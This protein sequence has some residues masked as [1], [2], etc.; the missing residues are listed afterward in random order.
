MCRVEQSKRHIG[1][2]A[3]R[4]WQASPVHTLPITVSQ[5]FFT[6]S[7]CTKSMAFRSSDPRGAWPKNCTLPLVTTA[8]TSLFKWPVGTCKPQ[9][10]L[11]LRGSMHVLHSAHLHWHKK[12]SISRWSGAFALVFTASSSTTKAYS[13]GWPSS[14]VVT[15]CNQWCSCFLQPNAIMVLQ[16]L[17]G[18]R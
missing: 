1:S 17:P 7:F 4:W 10:E 6:P 8:A 3:S 13:S 5:L 11:L 18:P 9:E 2:I 14:T 15:T 16:I 12:S